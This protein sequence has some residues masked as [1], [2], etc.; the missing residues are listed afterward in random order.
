[1]YDYIYVNLFSSVLNLIVLDR[2]VKACWGKYESIHDYHYRYVADTRVI[3]I[4]LIAASAVW[5][6]IKYPDCMLIMMSIYAPLHFL[7]FPV[8]LFRIHVE[9]IQ[10][11]GICLE[12]KFRQVKIILLFSC[13][14]LISSCGSVQRSNIIWAQGLCTPFDLLRM[15]ENWAFCQTPPTPPPHPDLILSTSFWWKSLFW[16]RNQRTVV[17]SGDTV[18]KAVLSAHEWIEVW[19][20]AACLLAT[21]R[22]GSYWQV[23]VCTWKWIRLIS[24]HHWKTKNRGHNLIILSHSSKKFNI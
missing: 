4:W 20:N 14:F 11:N 2:P 8:N 3:E 21:W 22:K 16:N 23:K 17:L 1:M 9:K 19:K 5:V 24:S 18:G 10:M 12:I 6:T 7:P 13:I 15:T